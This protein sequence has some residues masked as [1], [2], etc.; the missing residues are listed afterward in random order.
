MKY[1]TKFATRALTLAL[2]GWIGTALAPAHAS[3]VQTSVC[4]NVVGVPSQ[5]GGGVG[6]ATDCNLLLTFG[7][8]GS[9]STSTGPQSTYESSD[10]SLIGV[11]NNSGHALTSFNISGANIFGFEQDGINAYVAAMSGGT[12]PHAVGNPDTTGY[13][14]PLAYFT[15]I[16]GVN[17]GTVNFWSG[18]A[19]GTSTYFSLEKPIATASLPVVTQNVPEPPVLP[20]F[21]L[22]LIGM[23]WLAWRRKSI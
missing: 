12:S 8:G 15:N 3:A 19:N 6:N 18:L 17:S 7:P 22:G 11:I 21:G 20:M 10:D 1:L 5:G 23:A 14:G 4:P 9:I 2:V 16:T 13:G